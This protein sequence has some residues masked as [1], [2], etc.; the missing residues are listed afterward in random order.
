LLNKKDK[1]GKKGKDAARL[2]SKAIGN[3]GTEDYDYG[4]DNN[5]SQWEECQIEDCI[6]HTSDCG[7]SDI[8]CGHRANL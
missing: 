4:T 8:E 2:Y 6:H 7:D 1:K 5:I 3:D